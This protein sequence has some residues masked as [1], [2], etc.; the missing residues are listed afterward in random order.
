[1]SDPQVKYRLGSK[2]E[3]KGGLN[4]AL[5][6]LNNFLQVAKA[7]IAIF[8]ALAD[9]ILSGVK[10]AMKMDAA[11]NPFERFT[12]SAEEAAKHV[13]ALQ[14]I[15]A[16]G[17]IPTDELIE[18]SR[19]L[20]NLSGGLLGTAKD[21]QALADVAATTGDPVGTLTS[22]V[23]MFTQALRTGKRVDMAIKEL[24]ALGIV[25]DEVAARMTQMA[26]SGEA[27]SKIFAELTNSINSFSGGVE[28]DA[29]RAASAVNQMKEQWTQN[30]E[31]AGKPFLNFTSEVLGSLAQKMQDLRDS[32]A[33]EDWA[34]RAANALEE[35]IPIIESVFGKLGKLIEFT[36][37]IGAIAGSLPTTGTYA[38]MKAAASQASDD[39]FQNL[40]AED[41]KR[42]ERI[43]KARAEREARLA[44]G[45]NAS[46]A[47]SK[48][49]DARQEKK[50]ESA[51]KGP[52][53]KKAV[54]AVFDKQ[55][56]DEADAYNEKLRKQAAAA[57]DSDRRFTE[58]R[59]ESLKAEADALREASEH[60]SQEADDLREQ[61]LDPSKAKAASAARRSAAKEERRFQSLLSKGRRGI[62]SK[63]ISLAMASEN[64]RQTAGAQN[65]AADALE[66]ASKQ[67][68]VN[69]EK[70]LSDIK[71][72]LGKLLVST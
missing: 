65:A 7:G 56:K 25:S 36:N 20:M 33:I 70:H 55:Y 23:G 64:A 59:K 3:T 40:D 29:K 72:K 66:Q 62:K 5:F 34:T 16:R 71:E 26:A 13:Q 2:D 8:K 57:E 18:A 30:L 58:A 15:G 60:S 43:A 22:A 17:V 9:A 47:I 32:G 61:A 14:A 41:A 37:W 63:A 6:N 4:S 69:S 21:M 44:G 12:G 1:M 31:E 67:A 42:Q 39:Y 35:L 52:D 68:Q 50:K 46:G 24:Q 11:A 51:D 48:Q 28:D 19:Q 45:F 49:L 27:N 54:E 53:G 10:A 38:E